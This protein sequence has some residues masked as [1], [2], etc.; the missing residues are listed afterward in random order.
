MLHD[1]HFSLIFLCHALM[2]ISGN[3]EINVNKGE[4]IVVDSISNENK[5][6]TIIQPNINDMQQCYRSKK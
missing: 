4:M 6:F 3:E 1:D 5:S 2:F